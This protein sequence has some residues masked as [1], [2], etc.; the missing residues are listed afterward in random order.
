MAKSIKNEIKRKAIHLAALSIPIGYSFLDKK[1]ALF[2]VALCTVISALIDIL[3]SENRAI[4]ILFFKFFRDMLRHKEKYNFTGA[5]FI[6]F[7]STLTLLFYNKWFAIIAV[8]YIIVGDVFAAIIGKSF[9]K[10]RIYGSGSIEGSIAFFISAALFT[11]L[12]FWVP[13]EIVPIYYRILGA[14]LAAA[15]E[16]VIN[17][18]DD[19]LTVPLLT[20]LV[21]QFALSGRL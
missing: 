4:R 10:H 7:G 3:R 6:L 19:N 12:M 13:Y 2:W 15:I 17:Q 21:L 11:S 5:T 14:V 1:T 8:T 20:G 16:L 18:V 9:G